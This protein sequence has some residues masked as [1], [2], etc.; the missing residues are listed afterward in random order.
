[1]K[2][3]KHYLFESKLLSE[4]KH[5]PEDYIKTAKNIIK[6]SPLGQQSWYSDQYIDADLNTFANEF[7]PLSH[8]NS[9][10]GFFSPLIKWFVEYS[11]SDKNKYQEFIEGTLDNIIRTLQQI[12]NDKSY[13]S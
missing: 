9:S 5:W 12:L 7:G 11:G 2:S 1:M 3:F 4:G 8:K 13:D 10:L 6:V